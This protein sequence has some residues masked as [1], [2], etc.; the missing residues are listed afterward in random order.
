M[1]KRAIK[2]VML[3]LFMM[4]AVSTGASLAQQHSREQESTAVEPSKQIADIATVKTPALPTVSA[5][6]TASKNAMLTMG[7]QQD[8]ER[9]AESE[10]Q[11]AE[12]ELI[13]AEAVPMASV[14]DVA[15]IEANEGLFEVETQTNELPSEEASALADDPPPIAGALPPVDS[16]WESIGIHQIYGYNYTDAKQCG[17]TVANGITASGL[18]ATEGVTVA[19]SGL[20]FGTVIYIEGV[21]ERIVQDRGVKAGIVDMAF[22]TDAECYAAT[23]KREVWIKAEE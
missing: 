1:D 10:T 3:S 19:M 2:P 14:A 20:P 23:S 7:K 22:D 18:L 8:K 4:L 9:Q 17:K 21:G 5:K 12:E 11:I 15:S 16:N 6:A 13:V